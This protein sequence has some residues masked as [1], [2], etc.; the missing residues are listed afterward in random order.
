MYLLKTVQIDHT[1]EKLIYPWKYNINDSE[2]L[3]K[4]ISELYVSFEQYGFPIIYNKEFYIITIA[5]NTNYYTKFY[6]NDILLPI[7]NINYD[8]DIVILKNI[9]DYNYYDYIINL[10]YNNNEIF[11]NKLL[12]LIFYF[13][14]I[15]ESNISFYTS[16]ILLIECSS[17][18]IIHEGLSGLPIINTNN[19]IIGIITRYNNITNCIDLLPMVNVKRLFKNNNLCYISEYLTLKNYELYIHKKSNKCTYKKKIF[20]W[21][22]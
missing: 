6:Y 7:I 12:N 17:N 11:I 8:L 19:K 16:N 13:N 2:K 21:Y 5:H 14:K 22:I 20:I 1:N 4:N 10:N 15:Y 9:I 18:N 3:K